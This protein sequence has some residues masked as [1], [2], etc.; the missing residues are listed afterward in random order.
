MLALKLLTAFL[1]PVTMS[2]F[3]LPE[4]AGQTGQY[5]NRMRHFEG[6]V[7]QNFQ[8]QTLRKWFELFW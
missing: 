2:V 1:V 6:M 5:V 7:M 8:K 4:L 3:H